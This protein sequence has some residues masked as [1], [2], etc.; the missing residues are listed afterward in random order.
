MFRAA[1]QQY[2]NALKKRGNVVAPAPSKSS[3]YKV[4][5]HS[6]FVEI[7]TRRTNKTDSNYNQRRETPSVGISKTDSV[8]NLNQNPKFNEVKRRLKLQVTSA[9]DPKTAKDIVPHFV[10]KYVGS[11]VSDGFTELDKDAHT[12]DID[13]IL[14][15]SDTIFQQLL[16][17][18]GRNATTVGYEDIDRAVAIQLSHGPQQLYRWLH[19]LKSVTH[20]TMFDTLLDI[21][22]EHLGEDT[23]TQHFNAL[24]SLYKV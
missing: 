20:E 19:A 22:L 15:W 14:K 10:S 18:A 16:Q 8:G 3:A 2:Y 24:I 17:Q 12:A 1:F 13:Q 5:E 11:E 9:K 4:N 21:V 7:S 23:R 6:T